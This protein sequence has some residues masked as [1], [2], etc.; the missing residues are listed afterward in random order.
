MV[1]NNKMK[2]KAQLLQVSEDN[3]GNITKSASWVFPTITSDWGNNVGLSVYKSPV[4][5]LKEKKGVDMAE[6]LE[7]LKQR[8]KLLEKEKLLLEQI[9]QLRDI[10][11]KNHIDIPAPQPYPVPYPVYPQPYPMPYWSDIVYC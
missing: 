6:T 11:D 8:V 2:M 3:L 9:K 7:Q 5:S 1:G 4:L 10:L